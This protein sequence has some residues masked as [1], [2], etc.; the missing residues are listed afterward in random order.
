MDIQKSAMNSARKRCKQFEELTDHK[1]MP[2]VVDGQI[3]FQ[4]FPPHDKIIKD[5]RLMHRLD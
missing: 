3:K 2:I 4:I 5:E 1:A